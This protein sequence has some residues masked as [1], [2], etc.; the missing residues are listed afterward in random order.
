MRTLVIGDHNLS[1]WSLRPWLALRVAGIDFAERVIRL[2]RPQTR[3]EIL[4][5]SPS[6]R[7]PCL[8]DGD[9]VIWD[10]LAI[11]EY[12][13]ELAPSLWPADAGIRARAR[14][15]SAE[16]HA[17]FAALRQNMPMAVCASRPAGG[18]S[19]SF[20]GLDAHGA[21]EHAG[22]RKLVING[23]LWSAN[24]QLPTDGAKCDADKALIDSFLTPR[25]APPPK[26]KAAK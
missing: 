17:G 10:S 9:R 14:A 4:E 12:A 19:F 21:W 11:C 26:A 16:M 24:I 1:S 3:A 13:A 2:G 7:V 15:V 22:M 20:S 6:G 18:R 5:L 8:I 25:T 23:I